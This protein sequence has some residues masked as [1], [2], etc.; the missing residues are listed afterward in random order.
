MA[1]KRPNSII[2]I[3]IPTSY[4]A[5]LSKMYIPKFRFFVWK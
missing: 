5:R 3:C 1:I 2:Y 4:T